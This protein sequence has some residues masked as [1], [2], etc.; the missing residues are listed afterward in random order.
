MLTKSIKSSL[1]TSSV[2]CSI[3]D[4][5]E[6]EKKQLRLYYII[7]KSSSWR[8]LRKAL[9]SSLGR[10]F[11]YNGQIEKWAKGRLYRGVVGIW[12]VSVRPVAAD[13]ELQIEIIRV[14]ARK[15]FVTK[16]TYNYYLG[17]NYRPTNQ[18]LYPRAIS[19]YLHNILDRLATRPAPTEGRATPN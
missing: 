5:S 15:P 3:S 11:K 2:M 17:V 6:E 1:K 13:N 12:Q 18:L 4:A 9:A 10:F 16:P 8:L 14:A 19:L 7:N